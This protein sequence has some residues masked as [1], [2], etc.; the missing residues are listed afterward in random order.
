MKAEYII[1][2]LFSEL[3]KHSALFSDT[4]L[5]T[6]I[7]STLGLVTVVTAAPHGLVTGDYVTIQN[8]TIANPIITLTQVDGIASAETLNDH[9]LTEN[10][11]E[12]VLIEGAI[13]AP[14]NGLHALLTVPNRRNFTYEVDPLAPPVATGTPILRETICKTFNGSFQI[15]VIDAVT[16]N[17]QSLDSNLTAT[18]IIE[19]NTFLRVNHRISGAVSVDRAVLSYTK[20]A[21]DKLWLF[22]VLGDVDTNRD[23][24]IN[25]DVSALSSNEGASF[26][27]RLILNFY[28]YVFN[29]STGTISGRLERDMMHDVF[30]ALNRSILLTK[31]ATGTSIAETSGITCNGHGFFNYANAYYIHEYRYQVTQDIIY[32]AQNENDTAAGPCTRAWRDINMDRL[33]IDHDVIQETYINLDDSPLP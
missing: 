11:Q 29:P 19:V 4:I 30:I 6:S 12:L 1:R 7:S 15:T 21:Q 13:E 5:M 32:Q 25:T 10:W 17:Y 3:P 28:I 31:L 18:G 2:Q 9:D 16:F 20:Q 26:R 27:Q 24:S 33:N 23:R 22:V 8:V 14:Y